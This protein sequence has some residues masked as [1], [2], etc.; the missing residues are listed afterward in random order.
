MIAS[1]IIQKYSN[2]RN[3]LNVVTCQL[4]GR[5]IGAKQICNN[6]TL[7]IKQSYQTENTNGVFKWDRSA[8]LEG[9]GLA[10]K[11]DLLDSAATAA[12]SFG[13]DATTALSFGDLSEISC[14]LYANYE[15]T[16]ATN[17]KPNRF[18]I[19]LGSW[20]IGNV[21]EINHYMSTNNFSNSTARLLGSTEVLYAGRSQHCRRLQPCGAYRQSFP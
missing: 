9:F 17:V 15:I 16:F 6:N 13:W 5:A 2:Y 14:E 18:G 10:D 20:N 21:S 3:A 12:T 7:V 8:I 19:L 11:G 4:P 1:M